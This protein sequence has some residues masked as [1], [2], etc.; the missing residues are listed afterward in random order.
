MEKPCLIVNQI[1]AK[2]NDLITL[3]QSVKEVVA[4]KTLRRETMTD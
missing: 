2:R 3:L 4:C 1:L